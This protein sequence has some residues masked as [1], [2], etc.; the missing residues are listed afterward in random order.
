MTIPNDNTDEV[1][2]IKSLIEDAAIEKLK[3]G[4]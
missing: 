1:V 3:K 2:K 4:E